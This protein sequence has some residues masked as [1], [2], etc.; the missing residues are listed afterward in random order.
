MANFFFPRTFSLRRP[1]NNVTPAA[2]Q[3]G[4]GGA[5]PVQETV[6]AT[7]LIGALDF[8]RFGRQDPGNLP[9]DTKMPFYYINL[10]PNQVVDGAIL[11]ND[12]LQ[13]DLSPPRRFQVVGITW[14]ALAVTVYGQQLLI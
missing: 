6:L 14:T 4:F 9:T 3:V 11:Q 8:D 10:A 12:V 2:G 1:N 13:D 7:G 5:D